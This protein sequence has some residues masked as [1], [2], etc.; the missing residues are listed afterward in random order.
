MGG[1]ELSA[2]QLA[3][4][5]DKVLIEEP[6]YFLAHQ[7]FRDQRLIMVGMTFYPFFSY[8][9]PISLPHIALTLLPSIVSCLRCHCSAAGRNMQLISAS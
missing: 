3:S 5:G 9:C 1:I 8:S 7:I 2:L 6:T 4:A